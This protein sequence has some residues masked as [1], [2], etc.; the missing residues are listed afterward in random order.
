[1]L[2]C[3]T[4][5]IPLVVGYNVGSPFFIRTSM[6]EYFIYD[7]PFDGYTLFTPEYFSKTY[8]IDIGGDIVSIRIVHRILDE[9]GSV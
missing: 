1:M 6:E 3:F 4:S 8:L 2:F 7:E 9:A 5:V